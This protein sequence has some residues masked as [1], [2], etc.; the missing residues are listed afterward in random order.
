MINPHTRDNRFINLEGAMALAANSIAFR[1][2]ETQNHRPFFYIKGQNGVPAFLKHGSWDLGDM[3]GRYL[4]SMVMARRMT[5]PRDEWTFAEQRL[6]DFLK[7]LLHNDLHIVMD[8]DKNAP[9]HAFSQ[10]SAL[11]GLVMLYEDTK[12]LSTRKLMENYILGLRQHA[13]P[14]GDHA[15]YPNVATT[16]GPCSH[17]AGYQICPLIRFFEL[18]GFDPALDLAEN[19]SLW[20]FYHDDTIDAQGI[21]TKSGWEGHIHAWADAL[22]G[23]MQCARHSKKLSREETAIR[24]RKTYD[25]L[26]STQVTDFGWTPDFPGSPTSETCAISSMMRLALELIREGHGQYW[27]DWERFTRNQLI[28]N[29][30]RNVDF[31]NIKDAR[32]AGALSGSFDCWAKPNTLFAPVRQWGKED[33]GDVEGCCVNGGMRGLYMAY[34]NILT[35]GKNEICVNLLIDHETEEYRISSHLPFEGKIIIEPKPSQ[36]E[37]HPVIL[38]VRMPDWVNF[39]SIRI[40]DGK[41]ALPVEK[42]GNYLKI[43]L[44]SPGSRIR[45][46][47]DIQEK[48]ETV[49]VANEDYH[50]E[51]VCD[52]ILKVSPPGKNYPIYQRNK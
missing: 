15:I 44:R 22:S 6:L 32:V 48:E 38:K 9:D 41:E 45:I 49:S 1:L 5:Q 12:D 42:E 11:Y 28:E 8:I 17:M 14:R 2:D 4:E 7:L 47:F 33:D 52:T 39:S 51:W 25:W 18:T 13:I 20:S 24:C 37:F 23:I 34:T 35:K 50:L 43:P 29:Q 30:F 21:I 3:T 36:Q 26:R 27:N 40:H 16:N 10:G 31:L 19:L 46:M